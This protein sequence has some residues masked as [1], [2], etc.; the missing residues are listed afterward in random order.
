M[1]TIQCVNHFY[2]LLKKNTTAGQLCDALLVYRTTPLPHC[3][4][5]PSELPMGR[6]LKT[7]L[8]QLLSHLL[9]D[10]VDHW[11]FQEVDA[12]HTAKSAQQ[13]NLQHRTRAP[14]PL[15]PGDTVTSFAGPLEQEKATV[16]ARAPE[17]HSYII[18]TEPGGVV[19]RNR[20]NLRK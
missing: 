9:P 7:T 8:P 13:Y 4:F 2:S 5:S 15:Q 3:R 20:R 16:I 10:A 6:K 12:Q 14:P 1:S 17:P 19:R 18:Q 11:V